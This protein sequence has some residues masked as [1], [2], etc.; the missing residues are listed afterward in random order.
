MKWGRWISSTSLQI[1]ITVM[2]LF[3]AVFIF[4]FIADPIIN[5]YL[6]PLDTI[7]SLPSGGI[8]GGLELDSDLS[9]TESWAFH[10]LK[11]ITSLGLLG[12]V[13]AV[14]T[15]S[16]WTWWNL[17]QTGIVGG[18]RGRGGTGRERLENI[19]WTLVLI[20][21]ATFLYVS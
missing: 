7:T 2:L 21:I 9:D 3:T 14:F 16:P 4:G 8:S 11:G 12:C 5:L 6:D 15:V 1:L 13:K 20:G 10:F 19:S 18:R 17:R